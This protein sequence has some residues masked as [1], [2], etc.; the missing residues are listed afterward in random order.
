MRKPLRK[1]QVEVG[2]LALSLAQLRCTALG[3]G[4]KEESLR[5]LCVLGGP[6]NTGQYQNGLPH[7]CLIGGPKD[8]RIAT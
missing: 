8:G 2:L 7:P 1:W 6:R 3:E 4:E 5:H